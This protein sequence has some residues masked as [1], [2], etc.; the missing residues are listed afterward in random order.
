[1]ALNF[2][3]QPR[4][5]QL[6]VDVLALVQDDLGT[7]IQRVTR[8]ILR[9]WLLHPPA[10]WSIEP[11]YAVLVT[12][13][14]RRYRYARRFASR[15]LGIDEAW[16]DDAP[17]D[18]WAGDVFV[19]L[20]LAA[21]LVP[22]RAAFFADLRGRGVAIMFVVY[23]LLPVLRPDCF[24]DIHLFFSSWLRTIARVAD[25]LICISRATLDDLRNWL[26][27]E[28][29]QRQRPLRLGYFHMG[30]DVDSSCPS[31]GLPG[32]AGQILRRLQ[33]RATFLMV[34]T[35][36]PRKGHAQTLAAFEILWAKGRDVNLAIVGKQGWMVEALAKR[37]RRHPEAGRRLFWLQGVSDEYLE[38]IYTASTCLVAAS[39]AEGFGQPLIE[40]A[41]HKLPIIARDIPVFSEVAGD[42]AFYFRGDKPEELA[43][44]VLRWL[45]LHAQGNAPKSDDLPWLTWQQSAKTLEDMLTDEGHPQWIHI[46]QPGLRATTDL[47]VP[48]P[49]WAA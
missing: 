15:F 43:E 8:A 24:P 21:H 22:Q 19:G 11:V 49:G 3:P 20:D 4:R 16:A 34:G 29:P 27:A 9:Q 2:P 44:A 48:Q 37:L 30:A 1:L 7:G 13:G 25:G 10:G 45:S 6:L 36:E 5:R 28:Q 47:A 33:E 26:D 17:V 14:Y 41:R 18:A 46:W 12:P 35:V 42:H 31:K 32:D 39:L 40:A 23:D 38:K